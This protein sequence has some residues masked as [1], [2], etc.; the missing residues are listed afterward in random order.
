MYI[1]WTLITKSTKVSSPKL[2]GLQKDLTVWSAILGINIL[3]CT[4]LAFRAHYSP[5]TDS[6]FISEALG[7]SIPFY[8]SVY[9]HSP[10]CSIAIF[11]VNKL[12]WRSV[13]CDLLH[14]RHSAWKNL[15]LI[16]HVVY[17]PLS[18]ASPVS[19]GTWKI[20]SLALV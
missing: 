9:V 5:V 19:L 16:V 8:F 18:Q 13:G 17:D 2:S 20:I 1:I 14:R 10:C 11:Q 12:R 7:C 6:V 15:C 4:S 3:Y